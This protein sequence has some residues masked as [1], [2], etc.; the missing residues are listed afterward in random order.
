[1]NVQLGGGTFIGKAVGYAAERIEVPRRAIVVIISDFYEGRDEQVLI[2]HVKGAGRARNG[3]CW[4]LRRLM[5]RL[6]R[7]TP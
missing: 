6:I 7:C 4:G 3:G 1:M 5:R 2:G